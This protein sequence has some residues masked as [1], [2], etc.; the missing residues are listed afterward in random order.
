[1]VFI[2]DFRC[3]DFSITLTQ[4]L[5][6]CLSLERFTFIIL[7]KVSLMEFAFFFLFI[8]C[9]Q[10]ET[11]QFQF[12]T[13]YILYVTVSVSVWVYVMFTFNHSHK[14]RYNIYFFYNTDLNVARLYFF[15]KFSWQ[16]DSWL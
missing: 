16:C 4:L 6:V 15:V 1:M 14:Q 13:N 5:F 9:H 8:C 11:K 12:I 10:N 2:L 7:T 3:D